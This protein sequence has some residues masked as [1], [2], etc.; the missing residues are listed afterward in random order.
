MESRQSEAVQPQVLAVVL[1]LVLLPLPAM[2]IATYVTNGYHHR[3]VLTPVIGVSVLLPL[4]AHFYSAG[5]RVI[6]L[7]LIVAL[8]GPVAWA[9]RTTYRG[10]RNEGQYVLNNLQFLLENIDRESTV[11][12]S[13]AKKFYQLSFY[14][15]RSLA[16]RFV[17]AADPA[18]SFKYLKYDT[19]DRCLVDL[20]PWFPLNTR[21]YG[22]YVGSHPTFYVYGNVTSSTWQ[23]WQLPRDQFDVNLIK[24]ETDSL[25]LRANQ[26]APANGVT[27]PNP[28]A[29]NKAA[30][31]PIMADL[32]RQVFHDRS[33]CGLWMGDRLCTVVE[34]GMRSISTHAPE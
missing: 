22:E 30:V 14:A 19:E 24:R 21:L 11:M 32:R 9:W 34:S 10:E 4:L 18:L 7:G 15:P 16:N 3:Y 2:I 5:R 29:A 27:A 6:A 28:A 33:L 23:T 13:D 1:G 17:Y 26:S 12:I 25:L 20:R 31:N 8:L